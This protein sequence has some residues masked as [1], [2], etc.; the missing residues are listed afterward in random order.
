MALK[1]FNSIAGYSVGLEPTIEVVD[2]NGNIIANTLEVTNFATLGSISNI[3]IL[4]GSPDQVVATDGF[5]SLF[6]KDAA[7]TLPGGSN[8]SIQ[9]NN[10]GA[11]DGDSVF[12]Y[13]S[14]TGALTAGSFTGNGIGITHLEGANVFGE[15]ANAN[16]ATYALFTLNSTQSNTTTTVIGN[17]QPNINQVG[18][19]DN[20]TVTG[21]LIANSSLI[22]GGDATI[23]GNLIVE[24]NAIYADVETLRIENPIMQLGSNPTGGVLTE[25][26]DYNARGT[27][28]HYFNTN[29]IDA[30]MGWSDTAQEFVVASNVSLVANLLIIHEYGNLQANYFIGDGSRLSNITGANVTGKVANA[31]YTD[32]ANLSGVANTVNDSDQ[33]NIRSFGTLTS[34]QVGPS[35]NP[36]LGNVVTANFFVG[37][38]SRLFSIAGA[39]VTGTVPNATHAVD[40]DSSILAGHVTAA[41]QSNITSVGTLTSLSVDGVITAQ[42]ANLGVSV[43]ATH[44]IGEGGNLSNITGANV[45]GIVP[46]ANYSAYAGVAEYVTQN[47]Q[48]NITSV[49]TLSN[50]V[51]SGLITSSNANLGAEVRGNYF[52][53][54]GSN[55]SNITGSNVTGIV[56]NADFSAN[57]GVAN[58]ANFAGNVVIGDQPNITGVGLLTLLNVGGN[59]TSGN[60]NLGNVAIANFFSGNGTYLANIQGANVVGNV[61]LAKQANTANFANLAN[62]SLVAGTVTTNYQPNITSVG[63][64]TNLTVSG[65]INVSNISASNTITGAFLAGDGYQ[66]S[67]ISGANVESDVAN[68]NYANFAGSSLTADSAYIANL[69]YDNIQPNINQVGTLTFLDVSGEITSDTLIANNATVTELLTVGSI[70]GDGSALYN[71]F[72][73]NVLGKVAN[74]IFSDNANLANTANYA[75]HVTDSNQPNITSLGTL[76]DLTVDGSVTIAQ[77]LSVDGLLTAGYISGDGS[78]I[79][80]IAGANVTGKV[81]NAIYSD[82]ATHATSADI[83]D[84]ANIALEVSNAAQ[85]NITSLGTLT[86]L[87]I[88]GDETIDG[89]I[90]VTGNI[91]AQ[92]FVSTNV[93]GTFSGDVVVSGANGAIMFNDNGRLKPA[94]TVIFNK[95]SNSISIPGNL[96]VGNTL[97]RDGKSVPTFVTQ[98]TAPTNPKLGDQWFDSDTAKIY[99]YIYDPSNLS[100]AWVDISTGFVNANTTAEPGTLVL[101]DGNGNVAANN[102][103]LSGDATILGNLDVKGSVTYIQTTVTYVT[104]PITELGGGEDGADLTTDDGMDRGLLLHNYDAVSDDPVD[105]FIGWDNSNAE[106]ALGSNVSVTDNVVTFNEYGTLRVGNIF[107]QQD[108]NIDGNIV[109]NGSI[110]VT[111]GISG[112]VGNVIPLGGPEDTDIVSPGSITSWTTDTK[113]TDAIDDLNEALENVRN[114][115]YVKSVSFTGSPTAGGAG[116][117]VT[118]TITS[119]GNPNRYDIDWGDGSETLGA[120]TTSPTHTYASN[121]N[122]PFTV[123]VRAYNNGGAGKGSE[124]SFTREDYITIY[125]ANPIVGFSL[126]R[127]SSG[128]SA[129]SGSSLYVSEGDT[130]YLENTTTNTSGAS[131]TYTIN[132]GD[133]NTDTISSDSVAGGVGGG[134]KSHVYATGQNSGT[135]TKTITLTITS[136][137]TAT[138]AYIATGPNSTSAIKIYNPSIAAPNGLSSKTITFQSSVGTSPYLAANFANNTSGLVTTTAG[139]SIGR[140]TTGTPVETIV[141]S[142][143]AYNGDSGYLRAFVNGSEEGNITLT[144]GSQVGTNDSLVLSAESDYNLLDATGTATTFGLSIYSPS[145]YKGFTAK[146]S[147][148]NSALTVGVNNFKLSHTETGNTN[149]VEF[150]K[151]DVTSVPTV[152]VSVATIS[153]ATNGTYRY[154][155]G[156]PYYNTGSPTITLTGANIY[157]WIG[158]T[159]RNTSTPFQIEAGTNDE[160]TTGNVI[161][162]QTK[163]YSNLDGAV[164]FLSGG[165][166]KANTGN[167]SSN[168]YTIGSQTI[169]V[170]GVASVAAVQTIKF[171]ATNVNGNSAY[172]THS[173]KI[174]VF[175]ATPSGFVEDNITCTIPVGATPNSN[176]AKRI[177]ISS[178]SGAT[179]AY[180]SATNYYT[181]GLW[182]GAVTVAGTDEAIVRFNQL[183][184]FATD[185]STGYL[186]VGPDL[187]T[188]RTGTQYFRGAFVRASKSGFNVTITGKI[189]GLRFAIPGVTDSL[190]FATNG[191]LNAGVA[192]FGAGVAGQND[193][194]CADGSVVPTGSVISNATYKITFGE[195][196]TSSPGN[197]GNQVLFSIALASGDYITSWS[198]S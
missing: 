195:A 161:A 119:V 159:Y 29:A 114:N 25:A 193:S 76:V 99:Q 56:A 198:F 167:T 191:W 109:I 34:L 45:S 4:G 145:L 35:V 120:V 187:S 196:S 46:N 185:L 183:K 170:A 24:G 169:N 171:L 16:Y 178:A 8:R 66:I 60:A 143:Y 58:Y 38:G 100:N 108:A 88:V 49:G 71:I 94:N 51:V 78:N 93:S 156:I 162:T 158:Q 37:N 116:T 144:T 70:G 75:I 91:I 42:S 182:S 84:N 50:L 28:M 62:V 14:S 13:N 131:V 40:A 168:Q 79:S 155:S 67:N 2:S 15:V 106:F 6:F 180:V 118:L 98:A 179:P 147:K 82:D 61:D 22:V 69:V 189:S 117:L 55:L 139:S 5:G 124:A 133:G 107:V 68:A 89:N 96:S 41:D 65:N 3:S 95:T 97:T 9:Y 190:P 137:S 136:H 194:G 149:I 103:S 140:V 44:I 36:N 43:T 112:S 154:V 163:T 20:L 173:R 153:N 85:P 135:G 47:A 23:T 181:G 83:A 121:T 132:W 30:F 59:L 80:N 73:P 175:T 27:L 123:T 148:T 101:R 90:T 77:D 104:D 19:L 127:G 184:N 81:A 18:N 11:F 21:A 176:P 52:I 53:G 17:Y 74:A 177:V 142:T 32:Y 57:A 10:S 141:M 146:V 64:L 39:N 111:G 160:S 54:D 1:K 7:L 128:G 152:D 63:T 192:Y 110:N 188:G 102:L 164:T 129:L 151:D 166:P 115:T 130:F 87:D 122:S 138:P 150:V 113:V 186:P 165:I 126:Y 86:G 174:Q 105:A 31:I 197:T 92:N 125:T 26:D 12:T 172:A 72:G 157:N 48:A 33:P 134:R